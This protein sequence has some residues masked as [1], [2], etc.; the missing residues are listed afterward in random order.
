MAVVQE[1][2][3]HGISTRAVDDLVKAPNEGLCVSDVGPP[4]A[5]EGL[6]PWQ[7]WQRAMETHS[8]VLQ[9]RAHADPARREQHRRH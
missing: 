2:Y 5:Q 4:W 8:D 6:E 9:R 3:V 7:R 1:A